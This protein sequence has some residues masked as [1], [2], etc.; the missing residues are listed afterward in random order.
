MDANQS[1][2]SPDCKICFEVYS[3]D[4][5]PITLRCGHTICVVCKDMLKQGSMLKCPIDKQKSD[6]SSIKPAYD[7]MTLIEDNARAMQQMREKLQKEMEESMAKLRIQ[8]EQKK[9][10][11][12]EEIKRQE[13]AKLKAQLAESQKTEREK[14]KS[15]FEAYTDKHFKNL[16]AKM[17]SGKIVIDGWNP[18]PQQRRENFERGGNRIYWAWQ[19]DDGKFR[20]FSAQHTAMIESAYKSNFDKTRLTKSNFEVDFIRWKEI[21]NNWKERSIKRVN[22]KVGQPQ[23]SLMKNPGVWVLFDEPDIFNIEQAWVK[24]RKDI[25]FVTIEGTVTCDLVKFSCKIMD[26]EYPIMREVFN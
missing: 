18:P 14:L 11:E 21:E 6:I 17:R 22:T 1:E 7:M 23:W 2:F 4:R 20:E 24:N 26:Q 13:E 19:G 8:E 3:R 9:L 15:H 5:M 16:E 10:E 12:I 25:S